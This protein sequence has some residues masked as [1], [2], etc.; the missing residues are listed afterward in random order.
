M[1]LFPADV[2]FIPR[3]QAE[4]HADLR[5]WTLMP[6]GGHFAPAEEPDLLVNDV[7]EFF[8]TLR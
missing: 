4:R 5:R 1:A 7:R 6:A 3:R 8:R 2:V